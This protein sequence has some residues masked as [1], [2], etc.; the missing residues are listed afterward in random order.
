MVGD[1]VLVT[2]DSGKSANVGPFS[3]Q[4]GK[5]SN[6]PIVDC[7]VAHDCS[8]SGK[9]YYLAMYNALYIPSMK[10]NLIPPFVV[11]RQ[12]NVVNDI[13]KIQVFNPTEEDHCII[14]DDGNVRIP[15]KLDGT[16]SYFHTRKPRM[17]E[18]QQAMAA[19]EIID[20]NVNE[21]DWDPKDYRFSQEEDNML[22]FEGKMIDPKYRKR[23]LLG[24]DEYNISMVNVI[25]EDDQVTKRIS[26]ESVNDGSAQCLPDNIYCEPLQPALKSLD[27]NLDDRQF[28]ENLVERAAL[29]KYQ[30]SIQSKISAVS[31]GPVNGIS[32]EELSKVF[33]IDLG[34]AKRTLR[35]TTQHLKRSKNLTLHRRYRTNDRM[36]RYQHLREYFYMDTMFA[37]VRSGATT[38]GNKCMQLFVTDRGFMFVCP[39]KNK[40]DVPH[41]LRLFF[42][43]VGVPDAII[44]DQGKEQ[45]EGESQKLLRDSGTII[46]R[47]EPN[48]PRANR[49]ERYVGMFKQSVRNL[50]HETNCP[51]RLWD[52]AAEYQAHINNSTARN[53]YQLGSTTPYHTVYH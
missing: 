30:V 3:E 8:Y 16:M 26:Q 51:I 21:S 7:V 39:L 44:C 34:T 36:L 4:L 41:A 24:D 48:T 9:T 5:I 46:R 53:L 29:S 43:K 14:L 38:R 1:D 31:M 50:L 10:E 42:K 15:L 27:P 12:G 19:D 33:R 49:A 52:Y 37:S 22:D 23:V 6:V 35:N 45:I 25:H 40:R 11:R 20:L 28:A 13:P 47:I 17:D 32:P 2:H 18:Y